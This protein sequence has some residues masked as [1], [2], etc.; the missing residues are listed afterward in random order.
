M[1]FHI[2]QAGYIFSPNLT[3]ATDYLLVGENP[4]SKKDKTYADT[5]IL[6][7][8]QEIYTLLNISAPLF[9]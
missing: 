9:G 7:N 3:K 5:K 8:I 6:T 2:E 1:E 4:G